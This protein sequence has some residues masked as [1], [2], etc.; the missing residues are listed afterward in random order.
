MYNWPTYYKTNNKNLKIV[1]RKSLQKEIPKRLVDYIVDS[2]VV[3]LWEYGSSIHRFPIFFSKNKPNM[4]R[5][6]KTLMIMFC[7]FI[8]GKK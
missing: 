4:N 2:I 3:L 1:E 8:L 6:V 7:L 5:K